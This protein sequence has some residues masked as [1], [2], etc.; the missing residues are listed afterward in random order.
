MFVGCP[1]GGE[2]GW[3]AD[4]AVGWEDVGA[5]CVASGDD[6]A[7]IIDVVVPLLVGLVPVDCGRGTSGLM[8]RMR[9][10]VKSFLPVPGV[11]WSS[12]LPCLAEIRL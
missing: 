11:I 3:G 2:E 1:K 4:R 10:R 6:V 5:A 7:A 12:S 9:R 8:A